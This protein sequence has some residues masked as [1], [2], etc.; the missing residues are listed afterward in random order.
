MTALARM[1][2]IF[3]A[4]AAPVAMLLYL[5]FPEQRALMI[6]FLLSFEGQVILTVAIVLEVIG[7]IWI[8]FLLR[9]QD[10]Y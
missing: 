10:D 9:R 1:A 7:L 6:R 8:F 5:I 4:L 3:L 2:A